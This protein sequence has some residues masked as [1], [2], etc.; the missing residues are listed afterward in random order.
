MIQLLR[1]PGKALKL[2]LNPL[3]LATAIDEVRLRDSIN[4]ALRIVQDDIELRGPETSL[5]FLQLTQ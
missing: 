4:V 3:Q 1:S 2:S 5:D